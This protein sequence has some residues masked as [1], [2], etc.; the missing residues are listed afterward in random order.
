[1][2]S[3]SDLPAISGNVNLLRC[4]EI[5]VVLV[6]SSGQDRIIEAHLDTGFTGELTLP[7]A[8]I[9]RL[10]LVTTGRSGSYRIGSGFTTAFNTYRGTIRW[11]NEIRRIDVLESEITPLVG[12]GLM[13]NNNLSID[14][15]VGGDVTITELPDPAS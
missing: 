2:A 1:M 5:S 12:V 4:P 14:F 13:W 15:I 6:D 3:N 7:I 11:H 9:E 10:G 8:A